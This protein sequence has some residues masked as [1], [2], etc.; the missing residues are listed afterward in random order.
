[1]AILRLVILECLEAL[2]T[3][4]CHSIKEDLFVRLPSA[5]SRSLRP[6]T[7]IANTQSPMAKLLDHKIIQSH[8]V[9]P[10]D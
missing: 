1:L 2:Q 5:S 3:G 4:I 8:H 10:Q 7:P 6:K 9:R